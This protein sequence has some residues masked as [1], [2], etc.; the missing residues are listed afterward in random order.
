MECM[1]ERNETREDYFQ[2]LCETVGD[3]DGR[4]YSI[5]L[6]D[7]HKKKFEIVV[8]RDENRVLDG[9]R[10]REDYIYENDWM[11]PTYL[12]SDSC[13]VLELLI[14]MA[15]RMNFELS[16]PYDS[17]DRTALYF[18][19]LIENLNLKAFDDESYDDLDGYYVVGCLLDD[20]IERRYRFSGKGGIFPLRHA[21]RDQRKTELW[22]QMQSYLE[23][24][25]EY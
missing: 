24:N 16:D 11:N 6:R 20:F 13:S 12:D 21:H 15:Q 7:L 18:W 17:T 10:L 14:A 8:Q 19:E 23:E 4:Q 22:Y 25:Y 2:W 3:C 5:L 1:G 9:I